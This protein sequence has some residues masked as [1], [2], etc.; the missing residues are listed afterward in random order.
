MI[1]CVISDAADHDTICHLQ[2]RAH[3]EAE[4]RKISPQILMWFPDTGI[5]HSQGN[6]HMLATCSVHLGKYRAHFLG[7]PRTSARLIAGRA[8]KFSLSYH[9]FL[10][11]SS[12]VGGS[13]LDSG[14]VARATARSPL[15]HDHACT[16]PAQLSNSA[17]E[18]QAAVKRHWRLPWQ[19]GYGHPGPRS[20]P[21]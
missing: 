21:T 20:R 14:R 12:C 1:V 8:N 9:H 16:R 11:T 6:R 4:V 19:G 10:S 7:I 2:Y 3:I 15:Q 13:E 17:N 5:P 18:H